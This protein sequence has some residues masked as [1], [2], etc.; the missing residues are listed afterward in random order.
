MYD[1]M[2]YVLLVQ[3]RGQLWGPPKG[4]IQAN[5]TPLA[6]AI[7][8]TKEE[9]GFDV[10]EA[11]FSGSVVIKTRALYYFT[12]VDRALYHLHPQVDV[13]DNDANGI[14]WFRVDCLNRLITEGK[15]QINQHC[16][17]LVQKIFDVE[18]AF[19]ADSLSTTSAHTRLLC[20]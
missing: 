16:R 14:G 13:V 1:E 20:T 17:I 2:G 18:L 15:I 6:C 10:T 3:S 19:N 12:K 7:R 4:S 8:E 11:D 9:T 5:E